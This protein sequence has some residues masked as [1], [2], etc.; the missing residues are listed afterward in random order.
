MGYARDRA[1]AGSIAGVVL[2]A[3]GTL[4]PWT[5]SFNDKKMSRLHEHRIFTFGDAIFRFAR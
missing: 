5:C 2:G 3:N 1:A 4:R